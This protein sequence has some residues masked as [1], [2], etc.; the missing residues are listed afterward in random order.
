MPNQLFV[1]LWNTIATRQ[2]AEVRENF[3][4]ECLAGVLNADERFARSF[5]REINGGKD[6]IAGTSISR[7]T[8]RVA[9]QFSCLSKGRRC[10]VDLRLDIGA[11]VSIGIETKLDASEGVHSSGDK[12]LAKYL[13][14]PSLTHVAYITSYEVGVEQRV[15]AARQR[16]L[17][18]KGRQH[19][20][21]SDIY[22][23]VLEASKRRTAPHMGQALV[24][25]FH[26]RHLEP[27]HP[28]L[29]NLE[30]PEGRAEFRNLWGATTRMLKRDF[31]G[32]VAPPRINATMYSW[33][34]DSKGAWK[35]ALEPALYPGLLR[36]WLYMENRKT[37][38][39]AITSLR[40]FLMTERG[41]L[42]GATAEPRVGL[43]NAKAGI[44]VFLPF[45]SIFPRKSSALSKEKRLATVVRRVLSHLDG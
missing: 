16:Y 4:S 25:L 45:R 41:A 15:L 28:D 7:S 10:F 27:T 8:V 2:D 9:P 3:F 6:R 19:F 38:D 22:P 44:S 14:I 12:Q 34:N 36:I 29:P 1:R 24:G 37:R 11:R 13:A 43:G 32:Q 40:R 39:R 42:R 17:R 20:L 5:A 31:Y 30:T 23:L 26:A 18:P 33:N 35:M 21:W